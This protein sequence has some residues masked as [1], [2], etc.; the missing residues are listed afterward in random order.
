MTTD[1][2]TINQEF[3]LKILDSLGVGIYIADKHGKTLWVNRV[4]QKGLGKPL[5][6]LIGK[7]IADLEKEGV[8][9]PSAMNIALREKKETVTTIQQIK[10]KKVLVTA[11]LVYNEKNE[12]EYLVTLGIDMINDEIR[13]APGS[14]LKEIESLL[15]R[16]IHELR[17][18]NAFN[19]FTG[20]HERSFVGRSESFTKLSNLISKIA[21]V[22]TTVLITGETGVGKNI[23]AQQIHHAS[24]RYD[25]PF[26][27]INCAAI[28][29][30]L[31][32]SELF[33]YEK[34]AFT[35]ASANGKPGLVHQAEK[36]TLFLDEISE[37]PLVLQSKLLQLLQNKTYMPIGS[38]QTKKADVRIIAATNCN[39]E[40]LVKSGKF[41]SDLFYRLNILPVNIPSLRERKEDIFPLL[42]FNL[43][44]C[45]LRHQKNRTM[46]TKVVEV[47]QNYQWP[48]NIRELENVVEQLIILAADDIISLADLPKR[49]LEADHRDDQPFSIPSGSS[50]TSI[51]HDMEKKIIE[52]AYK[53]HKTTRKTAA[54]LGITHSMLMRKLAKYDINKETSS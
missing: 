37:L 20:E 41:R 11:N 36:G 48:G 45:N 27:H 21:T 33:G 22:D 12:V 32:E 49:I 7:H 42:Y 30:T 19:M 35:G 38:V 43:E 14:D 8:Y 46:S 5:E 6:E 17:K 39:L 29:A 26:V 52:H 50:L 53:E 16:Y 47:L 2:F 3:F 18:M 28:P 15:Q 13:N 4:S 25:K 10:E 23:Y 1:S 31:I 44:K 40:E 34:G 9:S 51:V 24:E 54:A